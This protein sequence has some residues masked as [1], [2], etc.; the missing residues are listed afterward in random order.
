MCICVFSVQNRLIYSTPWLGEWL[1][2]TEFIL[3]Q[4]LRC[5]ASVQLKLHALELSICPVSFPDAKAGLLRA[6]FREKAGVRGRGRCGRV[7][8]K[9]PMP[10]CSAAW[11]LAGSCCLLISAGAGGAAVLIQAKQSTSKRFLCKGWLDSRTLQPEKRWLRSE[12]EIS[13]A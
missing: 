2:L 9:L 4:F 12:A 1:C 3:P 7:A 8:L 13:K 6:A 11:V 10:P 5:L